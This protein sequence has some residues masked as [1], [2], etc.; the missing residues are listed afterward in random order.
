[1]ALIKPCGG[2]LC[3]NG[4]IA[5]LFHPNA[6]MADKHVYSLIY[7]LKVPIRMGKGAVELA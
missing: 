1:M 3:P 2:Q 5:P 7:I 6:H 4:H